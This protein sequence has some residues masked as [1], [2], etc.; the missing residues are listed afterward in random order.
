MLVSVAI[1]GV[2]VQAV[3]IEIKGNGGSNR[4]CVGTYDLAVPAEPIVNDSPFAPAATYNIYRR[5]GYDM[6]QISAIATGKSRDLQGQ[7]EQQDRGIVWRTPTAMPSPWFFKTQWAG[8]VDHQVNDGED[9]LTNLGE[10]YVL[11][12]FSVWYLVGIAIL[13]SILIVIVIMCCCCGGK[14]QESDIDSKC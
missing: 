2:C 6:P 1:L 5:S 11:P 4:E 13:V 9:S 8:W 14:S 3:T 10:I 12:R 7:F